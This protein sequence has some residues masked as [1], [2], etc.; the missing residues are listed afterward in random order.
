MP[1]NEGLHEFVYEEDN[2]G[3]VNATATYKVSGASG[4]T[5]A[6]ILATSGIPLTNSVLAGSGGAIAKSRRVQQAG[7]ENTVAT[8]TVQ[9]STKPAT[10]TNAPDEDRDPT[11]DPPQL[12][13]QPAS[14][15]VER[16]YDY[17][18]PEKAY[19]NSAGTMLDPVPATDDPRV[20]VIYE[21]KINNVMTSVNQN[22]THEGTVNQSAFTLSSPL[23]SA[24]IGAKKAIFLGHS[25]SPGGY[26]TDSL[27]ERH[28]W[29][30]QRSEFLVR[31]QDWNPLVIADYGTERLVPDEDDPNKKVSKQ[32][33][34]DGIPIQ[35]PVPL[36]GN[37]QPVDLA[38]PNAKP[39]KLFFKPYRETD[40]SALV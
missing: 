25:T 34:V 27:G 32:I 9:Y 30:N 18:A 26:Y 4:A 8:V 40:F 39:A 2:E 5:A 24:T 11:T 36:D 3:N 17:S 7:P 19:R 16:Y 1:S 38:D 13:T 12:Y 14:A 22:L 35:S 6:T 33:V 37:G 31:A 15:S 20:M 21:R 28:A 10:G 29:W 23:F